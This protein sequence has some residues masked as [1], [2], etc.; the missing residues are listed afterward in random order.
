MMA[1]M[2]RFIFNCQI[3]KAQNSTHLSGFPTTTEITKSKVYW[4]A[5]AQGEHFTDELTALTS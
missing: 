4:F 3:T 1:F 5:K 2:A